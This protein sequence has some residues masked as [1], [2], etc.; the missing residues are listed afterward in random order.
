[1]L[2]YDIERSGNCYKIRL[3]LSILG[4]DY[5]KHRVDLRAGEL[6]SAEFR[7]LNPNGFVPV[8]TDGDLVMYDS[9]AIL[10]YLARRYA[11][12]SWLPLEP[13]ALAKTVRWLAFEQNEGRYGLARSRAIVLNNPTPFAQSGNLHECQAIGKTALATL[14]TQ[15][16]ANKWLAETDQ[17]TIAD[18]ACYAYAAL[19]A[20]GGFVLQDYSALGRW[21]TDVRA[22]PGYAPL[23][24][25]AGG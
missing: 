24:G 11:A 9:A 16:R 2:L 8:L 21:L 7:A 15:L 6:N 25:A 23:P 17:P 10:T 5:Q 12:D 1:M 20:E 22:L 3:F 14:D 18:I 19:S 13:I 4:I